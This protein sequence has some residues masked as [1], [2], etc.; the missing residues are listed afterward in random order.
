MVELAAGELMVEIDGMSRFGLHRRH[1]IR[2]GERVS[3]Q[4]IEELGDGVKIQAVV[5]YVEEGLGLYHLRIYWKEEK[6]V[7]G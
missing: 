5:R 6:L 7:S 2:Y 1:V 4:T 3:D